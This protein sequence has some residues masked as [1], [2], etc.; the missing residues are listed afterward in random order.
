MV[1]GGA[2]G[3]IVAVMGVFVVAVRHC[4]RMKG[5]VTR[6]REDRSCIM[7]F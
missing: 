2:F 3:M 7:A 1:V 4:G 6:C 5:G